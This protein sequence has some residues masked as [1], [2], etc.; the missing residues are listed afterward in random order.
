MDSF[1]IVQRGDEIGRR[2]DLD[3]DQL[4]IG[5]GT[6]NDV[7][8][9]DPMV[10]RYHA[11]LKRQDEQVIL[12]DL[13]SSNPV[14]I[15]DQVLE[16]GVPRQLSHRDV[17]FIGRAVFSFQS[18]SGAARQTT[19]AQNAAP[20]TRMMEQQSQPYPPGTAESERVRSV[21]QQAAVSTM[22]ESD[23]TII[24]SD[25]E[26]LP[27]PP[28]QFVPQHAA[29]SFDNGSPANSGALAPQDD[30]LIGTPASE[31]SDDSPT[32]IIPRR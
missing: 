8:L 26:R 12:I 19:P 23:K 5:R 14:V 21:S 11:V 20:L 31:G 18:R 15:N 10:S 7:V 13:G 3:G 16:P 22:E 17:L 6:D 28:P 2:M 29:G 9:S 27:P 25:P 1:L 30:R 24:G 4:T 32:Q